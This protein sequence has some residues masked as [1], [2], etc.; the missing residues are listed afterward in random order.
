MSLCLSPLPKLCEGEEAEEVTE[1]KSLFVCFLAFP[2]GPRLSAYR[3]H[4]QSA[5]STRT[6]EL[7]VS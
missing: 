5:V 6:A 2:V 1:Q 7:T 4:I 3:L